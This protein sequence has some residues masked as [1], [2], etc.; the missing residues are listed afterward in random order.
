M[1]LGSEY[2]LC[3]Q[4]MGL[5]WEVWPWL[6]EMWP[7]LWEMW[8]WLWPTVSVAM[9]AWNLGMSRVW[10]GS[11]SPSPGSFFCLVSIQ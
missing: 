10:L 5:F 7:W 9:A 8:L 6:R 1:V 11:A 4:V 3:L 2:H